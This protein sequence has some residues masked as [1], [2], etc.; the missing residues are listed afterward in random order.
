MSES[1][2]DLVF[3]VM[4]KTI[5]V[6]HGY[7]LYSAISKVLKNFH[8]E[9]EVHLSPIR[10]RYVGNGILDIQP[11]SELTLRL[12]I[13]NLRS[14]INLAGKKLDIL[15]HAINIGVPNTQALVPAPA[16]YA[17]LVTTKNGNFQFRFDAEIRR[18]LSELGIKGSFQIGERRT[19]AVHKKQMVGYS[20]FVNELTAEE[21]IL[22]QETGLGGRHKMGCGF[23]LPK[24]KQADEI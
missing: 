23:F 9:Q 20:L 3:Q 12:P 24:G 18:Q 7:P 8:E 22:L 2:V 1:K 4:G 17:H 21:S 16:L 6:D 13:A 11:K 15:G 19:L 14:Y 5:P 10:G